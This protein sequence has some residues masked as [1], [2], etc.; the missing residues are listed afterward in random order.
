MLSVL[1]PV[2]HAHDVRIT[3]DLLMDLTQERG[4]LAGRCRSPRRRR[5]R[6]PHTGRYG[7]LPE[8]AMVHAVR[9]AR[10]RRAKIVRFVTVRAHQGPRAQINSSKLTAF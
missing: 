5:G 9:S 4:L 1:H 8:R 2:E 3:R 10:T 7:E 6:S